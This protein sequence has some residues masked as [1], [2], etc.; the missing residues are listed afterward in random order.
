[1]QYWVVPILMGYG[2]VSAVDVLRGLA[3]GPRPTQGAGGASTRRMTFGIS[4]LA[5]VA[6][7]VT[8]VSGARSD[9]STYDQAVDVHG[10]ATAADI[11]AM[12]Q[13][14]RTLPPGSIVLTNGT[15][16]AG[17]WVNALT[18]EVEYAP[19]GYVRQIIDAQG[20]LV[21]TDERSR[22]IAAACSDPSRATT[23]LSGVSAV[24]VGSR[25]RGGDDPTWNA[26]CIGRLAGI[27]PLVTTGAGDLTAH[28]FAVRRAG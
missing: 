19:I 12:A 25:Q 18:R 28:V 11:D 6:I 26:D 16:D 7:I 23:A 17:Q 9:H 27:S 14:D 1:M 10:L 21:P 4:G 13:M 3:T 5:A 22:A 2:L 24:Y 15:S 20:R 8:A